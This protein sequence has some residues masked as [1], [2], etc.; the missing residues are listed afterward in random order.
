M[1]SKDKTNLQ[2]VILK[3]N[4]TDS[5]APAKVERSGTMV[6]GSETFTS[7]ERRGTE[8][9]GKATINKSEVKHSFVQPDSKYEQA[10][11]DD[12]NNESVRNM[13]AEN[14]SVDFKK[15]VLLE[16]EIESMQTELSAL[17]KKHTEQQN[18][19]G[20]MYEWQTTDGDKPG[21][22]AAPYSLVQILFVFILM[23][24]L[25]AYLVRG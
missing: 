2:Q 9:P 25:G 18:V 3:I 21:E 19:N 17:Q 13:S 1:A 22:A 6:A 23:A 16:K 24:I 11:G 4:I 14:Q 7:L 20:K 15:K 5:A 10:P 8:I 12:I